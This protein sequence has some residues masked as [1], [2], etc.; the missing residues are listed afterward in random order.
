MIFSPSFTEESTIASLPHV[1]PLTRKK[2]FFAFILAV[3]PQPILQSIVPTFNKE[4]YYNARGDALYIYAGVG[5]KSNWG[6]F[7]VTS[8]LGDGLATFDV[9]YFPLQ[10]LSWCII[11]MLLNTFSRQ[12]NGKVCYSLYGLLA[13]YESMMMFVNGNGIL[14][15]ILY[16]VRGYWQEVILFMIVFMISKFLSKI[17]LGK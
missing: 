9:L 4:L 7:R 14:D 1:V 12:K 10:L 17:R 5:G 16:M 2:V 13:A 3:I 11:M 15:D 6:E 8:N